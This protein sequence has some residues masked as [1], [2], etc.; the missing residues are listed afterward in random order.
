MP[1]CERSGLLGLWE[2]GLVSSPVIVPVRCLRAVIKQSRVE[3][4]RVRRG[5]RSP[6]RGRAAISR[7]T[8]RLGTYSLVQYTVASSVQTPVPVCLDCRACSEALRVVSTRD[9]RGRVARRTARRIG[10]LRSRP[11]CLAPPE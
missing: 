1:C 4:S 5:R 7:L 2:C 6:G 3:S 9:C 8:A 10:A 11:R